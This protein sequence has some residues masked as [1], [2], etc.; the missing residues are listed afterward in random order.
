MEE[1]FMSKRLAVL[2]VNKSTLSSTSPTMRIAKYVAEQLGDRADFI[3]DV[4][5]AQAAAKS[6]DVVFVKYGMLAFSDHRKEAIAI[7]NSAKKVVNLENDYSFVPDKRLRA[8]DEVWSTVADRTRYCNWNV[9]TRHGTNGWEKPSSFRPVTNMGLL[10]YG[11]YRPGRLTYFDRYF[12][13]APYPV[14]VS[15]FR[16]E[17]DFGLIDHRIALRSAFR[18]PDEPSEWEM[19]IYIED[20]ASHNLYCSPANRFYECLHMGL[21]QAIDELAVATL[22]QGG[23]DKARKFQVKNKM[24]LRAL[25]GNWEQVRDYQQSLWRRDFAADLHE[26]FAKAMKESRI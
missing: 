26:Q 12:R 18:D 14:T 24:E 10:Y 7:L 13:H 25:I 1:G 20:I 17:K 6:Y 19:T 9:L 3:F 16:G 2:H 8:P 4:P 11:A 23:I 21:A 15:S 5:T 22:K